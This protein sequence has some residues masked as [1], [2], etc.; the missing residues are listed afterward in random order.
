[1]HICM[2][3]YFPQYALQYVHVHV[4]IYMYLLWTV[5][6]A[7]GVDEKSVPSIRPY[8]HAENT[9]SSST[10]TREILSTGKPW[11]DG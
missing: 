6:T 2:Y 8:K 4:H 11:E 9:E 3:M 5:S 1:M 10:E 7:G